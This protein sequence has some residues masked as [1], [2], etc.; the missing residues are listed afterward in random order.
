VRSL[1]LF[2][3]AARDDGSDASDIDLL[4]EFTRPV[5]LLHLIETQQHI[6]YLLQVK[7][8]DLILRR[9]LIQELKEDILRGAVEVFQ[10][11]SAAGAQTAMVEDCS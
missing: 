3:S 1:A 7:K 9:C 8:V 10:A 4:V 2:G 11:E 5:G 6:E